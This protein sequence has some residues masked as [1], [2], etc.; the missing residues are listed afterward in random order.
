MIILYVEL[1]I[2]F[3]IFIILVAWFIWHRVSKKRLLKQYD[4]NKDRSRKGEE[5]RRSAVA[6][7]SSSNNAG[8]NKPAER[9]FLQTPVA[10]AVGED[11]PE[12]RK[13]G[14]SNR[15][16]FTNLRRLRRRTRKSTKGRT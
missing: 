4:E 16:L 7:E 13:T 1:L 8:F 10:D 3:I 12:P 15:G 5:R 9:E 6:E 11:K 2:P 14:K